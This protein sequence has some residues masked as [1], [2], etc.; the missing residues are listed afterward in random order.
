MTARMVQEKATAVGAGATAG[1]L[2]ARAAGIY[3]VGV[4]GRSVVVPP[5]M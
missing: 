2:A 1:Y 3:C 4:L 5:L